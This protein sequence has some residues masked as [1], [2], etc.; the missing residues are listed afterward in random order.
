MNYDDVVRAQQ[1]TDARLERDGVP[2][3]ASAD[4]HRTALLEE[5]RE[6]RLPRIIFWAVLKAHLA[7]VVAGVAL[8]LLGYALNSASVR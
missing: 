6:R 7:L 4:A 2:G 1:A 3:F 5:A 8:W